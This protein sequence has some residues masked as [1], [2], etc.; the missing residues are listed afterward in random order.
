MDAVM[1][2]IAAVVC[3]PGGATAVPERLTIEQIVI[4]GDP[5]GAAPERL[6]AVHVLRQLGSPTGYDFMADNILLRCDPPFMFAEPPLRE[7]SPCY[8]GLLRDG[9]DQL[10]R[11]DGAVAAAVLGALDKPRDDGEIRRYARV[12]GSVLTDRVGNSGYPRARALV[13]AELARRPAADRR[14]NLEQMLAQLVGE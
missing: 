14:R 10:R 6:R 2:M 13:T 5:F 11:A 9:N 7:L 1:A 4:A 3:A 12:L 8:Y